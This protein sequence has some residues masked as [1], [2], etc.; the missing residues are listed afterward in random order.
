MGALLLAACGPSQASGGEDGDTSGSGEVGDAESDSGEAGTESTEGESDTFDDDVRDPDLPG[1]ACGGDGVPEPGE[2]CFDHVDLADE[3]DLAWGSLLVADIEGDGH[4]D[5]MQAYDIPCPDVDVDAPSTAGRENRDGWLISRVRWLAGDGSGAVDPVV[6][7]EA[8]HWVAGMA[9]GQLG[10]YA[11]MDLGFVLGSMDGVAVVLEGDGQGT[12]PD[13]LAGIETPLGWPPGPVTFGELSGDGWLDLVVGPYDGQSFVYR[14]DGTGAFVDPQ[15][16]PVADPSLLAVIAELDGVPGGDLA[17][18]RR[19]D[20]SPTPAALH[21]FWNVPASGLT[22]EWVGP[23][24]PKPDAMAAGDI[25]ADGA[26]E[27]VLADQEGEQLVVLAG[28]PGA[29]GAPQAFDAVAPRALVFGRFDGD[30]TPDVAT[31]EG[32]SPTPVVAVH[33]GEPGSI[34][35]DRI[36]VVEERDHGE[37]IAAGDLNEDGVDDIVL[38]DLHA[39]LSRP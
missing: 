10:G 20:A 22:S 13:P 26:A 31:L 21:V 39:L 23:E 30:A 19:R 7:V 15:A 1:P 36:D 18:I 9:L 27:L 16:V 8:P 11:F 35:G 5:V 32:W 33:L 37:W 24:L 29:L 3:E 28:G 6:E 25:D 2:V 38:G 17:V 34:L 4:V 14:N 12:L